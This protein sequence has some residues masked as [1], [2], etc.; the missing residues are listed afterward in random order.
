M[1]AVRMQVSPNPC[2]PAVDVGLNLT[3]QLK[4]PISVR[5]ASKNFRDAHLER[6]YGGSEIGYCCDKKAGAEPC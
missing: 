3:G 4:L 6:A 5:Q 1:S 2:A